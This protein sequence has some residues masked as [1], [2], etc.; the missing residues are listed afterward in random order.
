VFFTA[1]VVCALVHGVG[2]FEELSAALD[3]WMTIHGA[4]MVIAGVGFGYAVGRAGVLPRWTGVV[5]SIGVI[6]IPITMGLAEGVGLL[7]VGLR[8]LAFAA[9]GS[10]LL[11]TAGPLQGASPVATQ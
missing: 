1:T 6:L 7:G 10:A 2:D 5:L 8:D 3:P 11:R 4:V 9:M